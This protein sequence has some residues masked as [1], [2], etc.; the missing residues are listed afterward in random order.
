MV[1]PARFALEKQRKAGGVTL[2]QSHI[3]EVVVQE[4]AGIQTTEGK[5][6]PG[7]LVYHQRPR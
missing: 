7:A 2:F 5:N 3:P 1:Q 6:T 4:G